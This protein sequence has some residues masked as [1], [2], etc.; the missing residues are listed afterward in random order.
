MALEKEDM[1]F[2]RK[3]GMENLT[4]GRPGKHASPTQGAPQ[5]PGQAGEAATSFPCAPAGASKL[6][7]FRGQREVGVAELR[8]TDG[9]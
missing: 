7:Q 9:C 1:L 6:A 5:G 3:T 4:S 8:Q 2:M